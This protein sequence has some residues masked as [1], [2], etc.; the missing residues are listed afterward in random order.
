[1]RPEVSKALAGEQIGVHRAGGKAAAIGQGVGPGLHH[2]V[3]QGLGYVCT[4]Q[5]VV[6]LQGVLEAIAREVLHPHHHRLSAV[7]CG[8]GDD[9]DRVEVASRE[10]DGAPIAGAE[11]PLDEVG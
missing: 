6:F 4:I 3:A 8:I 2:H 5:I 10:T 1:M 9:H 11:R 7:E